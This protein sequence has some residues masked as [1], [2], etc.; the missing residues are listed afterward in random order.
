MGGGGGSEGGEGAGPGLGMVGER[1]PGVVVLV[2]L[3]GE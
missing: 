1:L 3:G 2:G